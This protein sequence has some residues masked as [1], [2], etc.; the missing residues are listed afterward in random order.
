L[1]YFNITEESSFLR[2]DTGI[3]SP[4]DIMVKRCISTTPCCILIE[5]L[6]LLDKGCLILIF[7]YC[8]DGIGE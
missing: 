1:Y 8:V 7:R 5:G 3:A 6:E 4:F 2:L